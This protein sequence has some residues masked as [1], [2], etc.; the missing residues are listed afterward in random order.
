MSA[1]GLAIGIDIGGTKMAVA[2]VNRQGEILQRLVLPT[3]AELGFARFKLRRE[4][5]AATLGVM[6]ST[7]RAPAGLADLRRNTSE[8]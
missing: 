5:Q 3:Q 6:P 4:Q 8:P 7:K 1:P 2:A